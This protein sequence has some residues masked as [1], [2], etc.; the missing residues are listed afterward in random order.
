MSEGTQRR[1][2]AIVSADVVG[3]SRLMG[4]DETGTLRRLNEH[5]SEFID[6]LIEKHGGRIVKATGDGLL[7]EFP[8]VVAAVECAVAAQEGMVARNSDNADDE[9]IRFRIGVHLG[10]V[11][12]ESGDIFGDGVN[13]ASR[14]ERLA[15]EGGIAVTDDAYRQVRDRLEINW[16]DGGEHEVKNIARPV[17]LWRWLP[18]GTPS[19]AAP[20]HQSDPLRLP[21]KPSI[22]VLPFDN[23]SGDPEQEY[24]VDGLCEDVIT[25]LSKISGLLVISRNSSFQYKGQRLDVRKAAQ[26]LGVRYILEGS[27]RKGGD[28][29]R[30]NAQ[31]IDARSD[32]HVWA[33]RYDRLLDNVFEIQDEITKEIVTALQVKLVEGEQVRVWHRQS[34]DI[35]AYEYFARGRELYMNFSRESNVQAAVELNKALEINPQFG[36]AYAILGWVQTSNARFGWSPDRAEALSK[37][38]AYAETA[39]ANSDDPG[40][41]YALLSS[42]SIYEGNYDEALVLAKRCVEESPSNAD[43]YQN[44]ALAYLAQGHWTDAVQAETMALRLNPLMPENSLVELARAQFHLGRY[45]ECY[46][47]AVRVI[48][49]KPAWATARVLAAAG[50]AALGRTDNAKAQV[51]ETLKRN[52]KFSVSKWAEYQTYK[53]DEDLEF[54]L[55]G[56]LS[57]GFPE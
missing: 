46:D 15:D 20:Q 16:L 7:I 51:A 45:Q 48:E 50:A 4:I 24:F 28:R 26:D 44:L 52:P 40:M 10:D 38:R 5:R 49:T 41:G 39:I 2:A 34:G 22:A 18:D 42:V 8:S 29:V 31:L 43:C 23:M 37:A 30:I 47:S 36:A 17:Q 56:L 11:I 57:A 9:T 14:V 33:E 35:S 6:P 3:Y 21:D 19:V 13:I 25:I 53:N 12:V 1:L 55:A 27:V 32:H 54:Y